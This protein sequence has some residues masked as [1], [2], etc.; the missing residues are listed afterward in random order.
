MS[1]RDA[2]YYAQFSDAVE[3]GDY[4]AVRPV[5]LGPRGQRSWSGS[6]CPS[7]DT[8][9]RCT[10]RRVGRRPR[11]ES[12]RGVQ[13]CTVGDEVP[14]MTNPYDNENVNDDGEWQDEERRDE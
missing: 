8:S 2:A 12:R 6:R 4:K 3:A 10:G 1:K 5:E 9:G 13:V 14:G 11:S 7:P